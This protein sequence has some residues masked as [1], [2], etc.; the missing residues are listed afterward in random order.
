MTQ[1]NKTK[2][3]MQLLM[4]ALGIFFINAANACTVSISVNYG[5]NGHMSFTAHSTGG[6]QYGDQY[7]WNAGDGSGN[8]LY[9]DSNFSHI[10]TANGTYKVSVVLQV[11]S[12]SCYSA[13]TMTINITNV[14][15]PCTLS[16]N[17]TYTVNAVGQVSFTSTSAGTNSGTLYY[18]NPG[19]G[20]AQV[21]GSSTYSH[22]YIYQGYYYAWLYIKD[23]GSAFCNDSIQQT[24]NV[25]TA[26][27]NACHLNA[28][29]TYSIGPNGHVIFTNTSTAANKLSEMESD[30]NFGDGGVGSSYDTT[31]NYIYTAN[32]TYTV[33]LN[34]FI[35]DSGSCY[36]SISKVITISNITVP[37]TLSANFTVTTDSIPKGGAQL[38]ST[39]T[40]TNSNTEY[41]WYQQNGASAVKGSATQSFT[42][43]ANGTYNAWLVIMDTGAAY[44][45]D[46]VIETVNICDVDSL[47]SSFAVTYQSD[48][49]SSYDYIFTSTSTGINDLTT[50]AW[51]P[52]DS[53]AGDTGVNM[54][55]YSHMYKYPGNHTVTLS[56]WY[57]M[58]HA[59]FRHG[60]VKQYDLS[61]SKITV[62]VGKPTSIAAIIGTNAD[63]KLYPNPNNG[64]FRLAI[65]GLEGSQNAELE[66][67]NLLG[68][69]VYNTTTHSSNGVILQ[70]INL[71]NVA[72]GTYFVRIITAD[73]VYNTKTM[74][75]R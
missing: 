46:S 72:P 73:K 33:T 55:T 37:C 39:S 65:N 45:S 29:F 13:D 18:W 61:T 25:T 27:S 11:D 1:K 38:T 49:M 44:C 56:I 58:S 75:N 19:D 10:Y 30:W 8:Q 6:T 7:T 12:F 36:D 66:I 31:Y 42:Y 3:W 54:T 16:A 51:D 47:H 59:P 41:F 68:E 28:N 22:T 63:I 53:T 5:L 14:T 2:K 24:I 34:A 17:Y 52:G 4:L 32:G 74:I 15:T 57:T 67:T 69:V 40:G 64:L 43:A 71:Q 35:T 62:D 9:G 23:T 21:Q 48:T 60:Q 70:D 50:Y 26:D 20:S